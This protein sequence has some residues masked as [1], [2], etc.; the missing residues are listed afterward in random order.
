MIDR[1]LDWLCT[2]MG[3]CIDVTGDPLDF[4]WHEGDGDPHYRRAHIMTPQQHAAR[5]KARRTQ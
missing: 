2:R 5:L 4:E 1:F 3:L